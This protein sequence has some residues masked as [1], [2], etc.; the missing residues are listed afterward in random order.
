MN[1]TLLMCVGA[2]VFGFTVWAVLLVAYASG[3]DASNEDL[4]FGQ[5][6][7]LAHPE[8][9]FA[10]QPAYTRVTAPEPGVPQAGVDH[11]SNPQD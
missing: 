5:R 8:G 9:G 2:A 4:S 3:R 7:P 11:K 1:E 6:E 10:E